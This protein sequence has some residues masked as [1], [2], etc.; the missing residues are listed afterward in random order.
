MS[1]STPLNRA[2]E[3]LKR[4]TSAVAGKVRSVR[5]PSGQPRNR[6]G[7]PG[8]AGGGSKLHPA[9]VW[10][11]AMGTA[12]EALGPAWRKATSLWLAYVWP[13]LSVVSLLGWVVLAASVAL[14]W[15][16]QAWGWQEAKSAAL[17]AFLLFVLAI[18]FIVGRS[19]YGVVLDLARTRVAVGDDAVGS[20]AVSN[21]SARPLL[22]ASL[23]LPV[24]AN[25]AVFHLPRMKPAQVHEDLFTIPTAR[26]AVI[27]VGPVRSVRADPLHLLRRRVL[28]T[29]P[30]DLFVH[31]R[32]VVLGSSAA[33]FIRDLEGM[34]TTELS[35]ADVSF[36]ALR[37]Y[38]PG[39][40][41]RHIHWKTTAR[42][43]KLMVR[44]FE[45]TRRAHL[46]IALSINTDEYDSEA[47][48]E[49][50]ISVAA[51]IGRQAISEQRD[52]D[53]L[54]QKGPL[55]CETGRNLLDD[56]TRIVGAPMRR[57]AVDLARNLAD[58]VPNASV[59][60]FVVGSHVTATELRT[61]AASVPPG[62]RSLAV[63]V[64]PGAAPARANIAD[65]TVLTVGDLDDLAIVLRKASA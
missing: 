21:V 27:V 3:S 15:A 18:V 29:E 36:H 23:E 62:V 20:I 25:T 44:Q 65:L 33:G 58:A 4:A 40:D 6:P 47:E 64:Q 5:G 43:N 46:A 7:R 12:G 42:T 57:T 10:S 35:S 16:G 11:E 55:R 48:F 14:W 19:A 45:E 9:A 26:R 38:V 41:R 50:A 34:P 24:G 13:V 61:C 32:T 63:R 51:S 56:T 28:W 53:V 52:L 22:P 8:K 17:V 31:P 39:D 37:D 30:V 2:A 60:F 49:M 54:T 59:V 1:S